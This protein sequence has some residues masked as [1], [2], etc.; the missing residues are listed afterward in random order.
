M[1]RDFNT[2]NDIQI[3]WKDI[4]DTYLTSPHYH[5]LKEPLAQLYSHIIEFQAQAICHASKPRISRAFHFV[6]RSNNWNGSITSIKNMEQA[7]LSYITRGQQAEIYEISKKQLLAIEKQ[8]VLQEEILQSL[9]TI[10]R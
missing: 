9:K 4:E 7:C 5:H 8:V 6:T 10:R 1:L 2:I 3:L